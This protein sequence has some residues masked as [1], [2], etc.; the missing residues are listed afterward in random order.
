[1]KE[2]INKLA[3]QKKDFTW[4]NSKINLYQDYAPPNPSQEEG[5]CRSVETLEGKQHKV[6]NCLPSP[7]ESFL[8]EEDNNIR[9]G[10]GCN[11]GSS[12][13]GLPGES[14]QTEVI[15]QKFTCYKFIVTVLVMF[16][17]FVLLL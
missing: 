7:T 5:I 9:D 14:N 3:W 4:G 1:M 10:G 16:Y 8:S 6:P 12:K 15:R 17:C 2:E 11:G 13:K